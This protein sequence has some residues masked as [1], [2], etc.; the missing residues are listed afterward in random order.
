MKLEHGNYC[1]AMQTI[2]LGLRA[3]HD[4]CLISGNGGNFENLIYNQCSSRFT[5]S[6][7]LTLR[8]FPNKIVKIPTTKRNETHC[9]CVVIGTERAA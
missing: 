5:Y 7:V 2:H 6:T 4:K 1:S 9:P 8:M 3:G